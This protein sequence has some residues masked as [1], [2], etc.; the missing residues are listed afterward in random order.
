MATTCFFEEA[1][2][3]QEEKDV[4]VFLEFGRSSFYGESAMYV[5]TSEGLVI[6]DQAKAKELYEAMQSLGTYLQLDR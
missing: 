2:K 3:D 5:K 6:L 4:T 1:L